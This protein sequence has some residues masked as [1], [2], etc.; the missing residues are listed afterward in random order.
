M[1][2]MATCSH[3]MRGSLGLNQCPQ[4]AERNKAS[5]DCNPPPSQGLDPLG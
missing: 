3:A 1:S 4:A 5:R 2:V